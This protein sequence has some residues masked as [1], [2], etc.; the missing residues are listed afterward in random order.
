VAAEAEGAE[1]R[2][3]KLETRRRNRIIFPPEADP[4]LE[5]NLQFSNNVIIS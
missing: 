2:I 1:T 3:E 4:P 5:D